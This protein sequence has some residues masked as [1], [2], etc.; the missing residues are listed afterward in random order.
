MNG[1]VANSQAASL[2]D[3]AFL[4]MLVEGVGPNAVA[5]LPF[6]IGSQTNGDLLAHGVFG[7][8]TP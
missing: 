1:H 2:D 8:S 3:P 6:E 5:D 7:D 4:A